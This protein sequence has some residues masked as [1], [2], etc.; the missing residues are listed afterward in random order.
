MAMQERTCI[1]LQERFGEKYK[2]GKDPSYW[3]EHGKGGWAHDPWLLL[4]PCK[5]GHIY[6]QGGTT[7]AA[8]VDG[9][10]KIAGELRRLGLKV[11][12]SGSDGDTLLFD[13]EQFKAVAKIMRPHRKPRQTEEQRAAAVERLKAY[14]FPKRSP[15]APMDLARD[16]SVSAT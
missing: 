2:I 4:I 9:H 11:H 1:D 16:T 10:C 12:Q 13:V 3:A 6:P 15:A 7:L 14:Q 5:F 8:S